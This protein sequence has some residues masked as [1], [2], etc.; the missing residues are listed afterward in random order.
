M[1]SRHR[2]R[3][4]PIAAAAALIGLLAT[5]AAP[6][7]AKDGM[8]AWLTTPVR[9]D[10]PPGTT[11][12][13]AWRIVTE[14]EDGGRVP[15]TGMPVFLRFVPTGGGEPV[16]VMGDEQPIDS[17]RW[18]GTLVVPAGGIARVEVGMHN[19]VCEN[20]SCTKSDMLFDLTDDSLVTGM[21]AGGA[22]DGAAV[23]PRASAAYTPV[24]PATVATSSPAEATTTMPLVWLALG[25]AF[26]L[27]L[28]VSLIIALGRIVRSPASRA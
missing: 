6:L 1:T 28:A 10:T 7:L 8:E 5:S 21:A 26:G 16:E 18:T 25:L 20:G 4:L 15:V 14:D 27:A 23:A 22:A 9:L 19:E 3:L 17:G 11:L 13:V 12:T 2:T 24:Q